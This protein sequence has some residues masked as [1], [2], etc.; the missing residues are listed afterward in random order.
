MESESEDVWPVDELVG[1][2][3][4]ALRAA[5]DGHG[6]V[7]QVLRPLG[8]GDDDGRGAIGLHAAVE[9]AHG[10]GDEGRGKVVF[11]RQGPAAHHGLVVQLSV[12]P[13]GERN[14]PRGFGRDAVFLDIAL[15]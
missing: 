2:V 14:R 9:L 13:A 8:G 1:P 15:R 5:Q 4:V 10:L 6:D 3:G 11:H 12:A 7:R